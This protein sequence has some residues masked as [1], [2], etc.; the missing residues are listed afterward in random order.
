MLIFNYV[1]HMYRQYENFIN[2]Q[3]SLKTK[4]Y[5]FQVQMFGNKLN[6][7]EERATALSEMT[8]GNSGILD[9][10]ATRGLEPFQ[11]KSTLFLEKVL[12]LRELMEPIQ[13][14]F[15]SKNDGSTGDKG[16]RPPQTTVA[17]AG[18][19]T[20]NYDSNKNKFSLNNCLC[21]GKVLNNYATADG[22]FCNNSCKEDYCREV[23]DENE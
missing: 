21:C 20:K 3:L 2:F 4:K 23:L 6:K 12:K 5:K 10:H 13:S 19:N 18:E 1:E 16:G 11:V 17:E 9:Y 15:N 8:L 22:V 14:M 7:T